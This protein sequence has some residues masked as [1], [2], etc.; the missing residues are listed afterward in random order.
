MTSDQGLHHILTICNVHTGYKCPPTAAM[1]FQQGF[2]EALSGAIDFQ[3][4]AKSPFGS[5]AVRRQSLFKVILES[6]T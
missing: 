1:K 4:E 3:R 5:M 2:L 6:G